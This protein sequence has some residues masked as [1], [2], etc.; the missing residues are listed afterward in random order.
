MT[1]RL[2]GGK[3]FSVTALNNSATNVYIQSATLNGVALDVPV[4][5]YG[6][7]VRGGTL[8]FVMGASPSKWGAGWR[9]ASLREGM[10]AAEK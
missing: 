10:K 9:P 3:S 7:I 2:A 8:R 5:R 6:D 4:I 1:L